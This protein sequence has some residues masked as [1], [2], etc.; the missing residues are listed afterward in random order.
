MA[1]IRLPDKECNKRCE[2]IRS[3]I[4]GVC[5]FCGEELKLH[6]LGKHR[7]TKMGC[8]S[9]EIGF[10][11][12]MCFLFLFLGIALHFVAKTVWP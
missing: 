11:I 12:M 8:P 4:S 9:D 2:E 7:S 1:Y 6:D 10:D 3:V 5:E